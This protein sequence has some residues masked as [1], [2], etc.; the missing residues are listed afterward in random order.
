MKIEFKNREILAAAEEWLVK[1]N[2]AWIGKTVDS[3]L[4]LI[5][6]DY[7]LTCEVVDSEGED[8]E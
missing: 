2:P 7:V 6:N 8:E 5:G 1:R 4:Q 3:R